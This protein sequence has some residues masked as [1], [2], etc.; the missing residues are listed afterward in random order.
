MEAGFAS[1]TALAPLP[2]GR[3]RLARADVEASQRGRML[4]AMVR[5]VAKKGYP[6]TTVADVISRA[7]VSRR[8]FYR[9]VREQGGVL[10]RRLRRGVEY[11]L[12][13][14]RTAGERL[15]AGAGWRARNRS[16]LR[17]Y[18]S[19][20]V[21]DP[22]FAWALHV[23]VLAA[24]P[25]ALERRAQ[26]FTVFSARTR[27]LHEL[28]RAEEPGLPALPDEAFLVHT[29]G[30]EELVRECLRSRGAAS[31]PELAEPAHRATVAL[32][33]ARLMP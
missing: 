5:A 8:T 10:H 28:A 23:E 17:A 16:D 6:A 15:P 29:G 18:L 14:I 26:I 27:R 22:A 33:G 4:S 12:G 3:H 24:G 25:A 19:V 31:L 7:S 2:S 9:A 13:Q 30:I 32:F 21:A 1:S 11:L 20:L